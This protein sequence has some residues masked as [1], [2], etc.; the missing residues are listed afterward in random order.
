[1]KKILLRLLYSIAITISS[2]LSGIIM[3]SCIWIMYGLIKWVIK[4][5][6]IVDYMEEFILF[7]LDL[8]DKLLL[9]KI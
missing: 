7:P 8:C 6:L 9:S 4:G 1:M 3:I 5:D 2:L